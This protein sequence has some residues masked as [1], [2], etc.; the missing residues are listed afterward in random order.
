MFVPRIL[1]CGDPKNFLD[2]K[3]EVIGQISFRGAAERGKF[4]LFTDLKDL[5]N[6]PF[7]ET[8]FQIFLDGRKISCDALKRILDGTADYIVFEDDEEFICRFNELYRLGLLDRFITRKNLI[9]HAADNF[10]SLQNVM[11]LNKIFNRLKISHLLDADNFLA[12]NNL[13]CTSNFHAIKIDAVDKNSFAEKFPVVRDFYEKIYSTPNDCRFKTYDAL[14]LTA[15]RTPEEFIDALIETDSLAENILTFARK[16]SAL[17]KFLAAHENIFEK[18]SRF[19]AVNG[20]WFLLK[21]FVRKDFKI[22]V[23][24]H[25]DVKLETLP[26]GYEIIHVRKIFGDNINHLNLYLNE[27][28]ALYWIWKNTSHEIIGLNHYRRFFTTD[29]KNFLTET[30]AREILNDCDIV[31]VKGELFPLTQHA[32]KS[33]LCGNELNDFV[34][35]IFREHIRQKQPDYLDA[36]DYVSAGYSEFMYEMFITRRKIF[37][38]YCEWLFSFIIGVTEEVLA[39][40]N[41]AKIDNPRKYRVVGLI[42][43]RLMTVWLIK[44]RLK[45]KTLPI[46]FRDDV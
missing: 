13:F 43:E 42:S 11:D 6:L 22:Y 17:E 37:D 27:V 19:P 8:D 33:V 15:E 12:K 26:E 36:F 7:D 35:K 1:L 3:V 4:F 41:I 31:V 18:I 10:F 45:I 29:G 21:K 39:R 9:R 5:N 32:L 30:Q 24:T 23:V 28:T 25:K 14:L 34:E 38:A 16:N 20:D 46:I 44:N 40:T 2:A